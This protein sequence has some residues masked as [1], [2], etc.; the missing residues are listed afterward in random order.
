MSA[1][2]RGDA[3]A[4]EHS[5]PDAGVYRGDCHVTDQS[6]DRPRWADTEKLAHFE[7]NVARTT[8]PSTW[9]ATSVAPWGTATCKR[10]RPVANGRM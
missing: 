9:Q 3:G 4:S 10:S 6:T 2:R 8:E 5:V 7:D 1:H